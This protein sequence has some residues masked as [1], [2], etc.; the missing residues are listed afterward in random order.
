ME[1]GTTISGTSKE[2]IVALT[3]SHD[4]RGPYTFD[5]QA[6]ML[7]E[8]FTR[9]V[10]VQLTRVVT[11]ELMLVFHLTEAI[12]SCFIHKLIMR[13]L[14]VSLCLSTTSPCTAIGLLLRS[15]K[16]VV[17]HPYGRLLIVVAGGGRAIVIQTSGVLPCHVGLQSV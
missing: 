10:E 5:P 7:L 11:E 16:I 6:S 3:K 14:P 9:L 2:V 17:L 15:L 13:L 1:N 12:G 4:L 8:D